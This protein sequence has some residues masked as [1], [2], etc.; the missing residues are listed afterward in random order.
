MRSACDDLYLVGVLG[1]FD[2]LGFSFGFEI[3]EFY[4][5]CGYWVGTCVSWG[6]L[7]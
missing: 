7:H 4:Y 5:V 1:R 3:R 6:S 2:R